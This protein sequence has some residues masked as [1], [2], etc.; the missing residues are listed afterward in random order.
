MDMLRRILVTTDFSVNARK[1]YACAASLAE[2]SSLAEKLRA[3]I[4]LVHFAHRRVPMFS[5]MSQ[6]TYVEELRKALD[7]EGR[8]DGFSDIN[9]ETHLIQHSHLPEAL[10]SFEREAKIDLAITSTHG[11]TGLQHFVFGSFA[12]RILR[13][14]SVPV[15]VPRQRKGGAAIGEPK[16]GL[17]PFD[18]SDAALGTF[19]TVRFLATHYRYAFRWKAIAGRT[20]STEQYFTALKQS[21][22]ADIDVVLHTCQGVPAAEIVHRARDMDAVLIVIGTHGTLGSVA[23]NVTRE[24]HCSVLTVPRQIDDK[25]SEFGSPKEVI[26]S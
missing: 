9:V 17:V 3:G 13:N 7:E 25:N 16:L 18:F 15:L 22:L 5:G 4:Y 10:C 23:Q 20:E 2:K 1:A 19:P 11:R 6:E 21:E 26:H 14:S 24:V 8:W 12:E